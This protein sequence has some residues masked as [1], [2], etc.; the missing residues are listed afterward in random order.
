MELFKCKKCGEE[1]VIYS[2]EYCFI[3][4]HQCVKRQNATCKKCLGKKVKS[5][6]EYNPLRV[7][8]PYNH[9]DLVSI[10]CRIDNHKGMAKERDVLPLINAYYSV[11]ENIAML[12]Y[13]EDKLSFMY[14]K[15]KEFI[16][17]ISM[18][19]ERKKYSRNGKK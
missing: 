19:A 10:V 2:Y 9:S 4:K 3:E 11:Y 15:L 17:K 5:P 6:L 13:E 14:L 1:K 18:K 12:P 7:K 16:K 8:E